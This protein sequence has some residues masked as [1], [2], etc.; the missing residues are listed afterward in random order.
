MSQDCEY[1]K[2]YIETSNLV[3]QCKVYDD[4]IDTEK[5][6]DFDVS[7]YFPKI[8]EYN[9]YTSYKTMKCYKLVFDINYFKK[10]A[11]SI[12]LL[13]F[14]FFYLIFDIWYIVRGIKPLE[15]ETSHLI[16]E[17]NVLNNDKNDIEIASYSFI[18]KEKKPITKIKEI[19]EKKEIKNTRMKNKENTRIE[20]KSP[21]KEIKNAKIK[22]KKSSPP[23][24]RIK[25]KTIRIPSP[26]NKN[27]IEKKEE[28]KEENLKLIDIIKRRRRSTLKRSHIDRRNYK[29]K[30]EDDSVKSDKVI[31]KKQ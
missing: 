18:L 19:K 24:K 13:I 15:I 25:G 30:L 31:K 21:K 11:G 5:A 28:K 4:L 17:E 29:F 22:D 23:P 10:N 9:K 2:F 20:N 26:E 14:L 6:Y 8:S 27:K 3:C 7:G 1:S 16:F 12:I